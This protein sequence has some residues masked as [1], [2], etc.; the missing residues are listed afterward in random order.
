MKHERRE[1]ILTTALIVGSARII[2]DLSFILVI[3]SIDFVI[4]LIMEA[5]QSSVRIE[6]LAE[7]V[8]DEFIYGLHV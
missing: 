4:C 2:P 3:R 7:P 8:S 1:A 6:D 5:D